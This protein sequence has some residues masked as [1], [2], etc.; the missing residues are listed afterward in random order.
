[1]VI[2]LR[3][4]QS[5]IIGV[6][7]LNDWFKLVKCPIIGYNAPWLV[8]SLMIRHNSLWLAQIGSMSNHSALW[9]IMNCTLWIVGGGIWMSLPTQCQCKSK[10]NF[11]HIFH[12][13]GG[14]TLPC[15]NIFDQVLIVDA[16]NNFIVHAPSVICKFCLEGGVSKT[17]RW[18]TILNIV[19]FKI[20]LK[21]F[22]P[23]RTHIILLVESE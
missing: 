8:Q 21:T 10:L 20:E 18:S 19:F 3:L 9:P 23:L 16:R 1:M 6:Y 14:H 12:N 22:I 11:H 7:A 4:V 13:N 5:L 2:M 17:N 15:P